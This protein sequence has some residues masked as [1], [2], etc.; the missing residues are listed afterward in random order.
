MQP[1]RSDT[2]NSHGRGGRPPSR[3]HQRPLRRRACARRRIVLGRARRGALPGRRERLRQEH[4]DQGDRRR[5][6]GRARRAHRLFRRERRATDAAACPPQGRRRDLAGSGAV[7]GNVGGREHRVRRPRRRAPARQLRRHPRDRARRARQAR[8]YARPR[9][10]AEQ[11]ADLGTP[12][13]GHRARAW[14]ARLGSSSWTSRP[15]R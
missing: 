3:T 15:P 5:L 9:R 2:C 8:R 14:R 10:A 1:V 6:S 11:P 4:A 13:G 12:V 7:S